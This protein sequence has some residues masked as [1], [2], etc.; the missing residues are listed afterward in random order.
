MAQINRLKP[1][2]L[3][4]TGDLVNKNT[5]LEWKTFNAIYSR[6]QCA[7]LL[8][9]RQPRRHPVGVSGLSRRTP[10]GG[11]RM[12]TIHSLCTANPLKIVC[13]PEGGVSTRSKT[14]GCVF[15]AID[16]HT[17]VDRPGAD[18]AWIRERTR[19]NTRCDTRVSLW[20]IIHCPVHSAMKLTGSK[21]GDEL[22]ALFK[23]HRV[24]AYL[25]GH[26]HRASRYLI[27]ERNGA[28]PL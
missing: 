10:N 15:L 16:T 28:R 5:P 24:T 13:Q 7:T 27:V 11:P 17:R 2:F 18:E 26:R 25:V 23:K 19:A 21:G 4:I 1:E 20:V 9:T 3:V 14:S 12:L 8:D 6:A 22:L